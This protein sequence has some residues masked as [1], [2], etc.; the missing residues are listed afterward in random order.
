MQDFF[1]NNLEGLHRSKVKIVELF[2]R[3]Y[4]AQMSDEEWNIKRYEVVSELKG[5]HNNDELRAFVEA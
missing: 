1:L 3:V 5:V 2:G 4:F